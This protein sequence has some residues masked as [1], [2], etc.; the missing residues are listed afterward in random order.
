[1]MSD[2]RKD[3]YTD[4]YSRSDKKTNMDTFRLLDEYAAE[5]AH[6]REKKNR[7]QST[8]LPDNTKIK[9]R[10]RKK[11]K[12]PVKKIAVVTAITLLLVFGTMGIYLFNLLGTEPKTT[13]ASTTAA[14]SIKQTSNNS[15]ISKTN[16]EPSKEESSKEPPFK[17]EMRYDGTGLGASAKK[18]L[19]SF[20]TSEFAVLYDPDTDIVLYR[21]NSQKKLYPASTTKILTAITASSVIK[22]KNLQ[23][24]VGD[25]I[26]LIGLESSVAGLK[27]G[28]K[29]SFEMLMDALMLPSGND[30]AYTMAVTTARIYKNDK[31]LSNEKA[32]KVFMQLVNETAK[33][34]G[35]KGTHFVT[36]DGWHD[37][38][39][40]TTAEDLALF[41]AYAKTVPIV[42]NS[43]SKENA[44]W[45]LLS[46]EKVEWYNSNKLIDSESEH[47]STYCDGVKTGFTDQAGTS[48]VSSATVDGRTLIAVA[49]NGYTLDQK[50][51]DCNVLFYYGFKSSGLAYTYTNFDDVQK[52][53]KELTQKDESSKTENSTP[54]QSKSSAA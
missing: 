18:L 44:K 50:Y 25:E 43:F 16:T 2:N 36:P 46:G 6:R 8:G 3:L 47:F 4:I 29:L 35:A 31:K 41:A 52:S 22:D 14:T 39:H 11:N 20:I 45:K 37:D 24:T 30:A 28:M 26:E 9:R 42:K 10:R 53:I 15:D 49:M 1:M 13:E 21:K 48:V 7:R 5:E 34:L 12:N 23:I 33:K 17:K 38:D 40:Y 19:D 51:I 32:V 54:E 27:K